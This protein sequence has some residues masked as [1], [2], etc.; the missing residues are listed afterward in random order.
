MFRKY[1]E[2]NLAADSL[3]GYYGLGDG[4]LS[5]TARLGC[6]CS[7]F[8]KRFGV[9]VKEPREKLGEPVKALILEVFL[10]RSKSRR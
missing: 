4:A 10:S 1:T 2:Q 9:S 6:K 3:S 7:D 8:V 5:I